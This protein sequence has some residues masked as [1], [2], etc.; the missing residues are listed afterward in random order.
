MNRVVHP[1]LDQLVIVFIDDILVHS[2]NAKEH[3]FHLRIVLQ[4]LRDRQYAKFSKCE[5]W[6]NDI[7]FLGHV[8]SRNDIF[9]DSKKVETIVK[10]E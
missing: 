4:T 3:T 2:K 7:V 10:W 8:V 6:L 5:F 9:M 1:N